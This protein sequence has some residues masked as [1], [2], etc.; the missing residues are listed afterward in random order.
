[1]DIHSVEKLAKIMAEFNL[2]D[3][4]L[5]DDKGVKIHLRR[6][7]SLGT[8]VAPQ[9]Q[10]DSLIS[11]DGEKVSDDD[12]E[13]IRSPLVGTFYRAPSPDVPDFVTV[14]Q[15][16]QT[17]Q[18]VCIVEAMKLMNEITIKSSGVI[19][20]ILVENEQ[21]VQYNQILFKVRKNK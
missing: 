8:S 9:I 4:E 2:H 5:T 11:D 15:R 10:G 17:G 20:E 14:G 18:T 7:E 16:V 12:F 3:L 19:E 1:M 21:P 6:P 13:E